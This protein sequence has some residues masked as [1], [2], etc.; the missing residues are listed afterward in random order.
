MNLYRPFRFTASSTRF[1]LPR[2][3][4]S[5][6]RR[7][8]GR[9][10]TADSL[11]SLMDCLTSRDLALPCCSPDSLPSPSLVADGTMSVIILMS[12]LFYSLATLTS[13]D[14]CYATHNCGV[15]I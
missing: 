9:E 14:K 5:T 8:T 10:V 15:R 3:L 11:K 6:H 2:V 7:F 12:G 13:L 4:V 1:K